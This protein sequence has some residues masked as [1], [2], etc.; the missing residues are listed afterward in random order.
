MSDDDGS[1]LR[2]LR[3]MWSELDPAPDGLV[4][5]M[6]FA[7]E[8]E[9]LDVDLSPT[10]LDRCGGVE[11]AGAR[12]GDQESARTVTFGSD[13]LTVIITL[14]GSAEEGHRLDGW[15]VPAE[16]LRVE[17]RTAH[18]SRWTVADATGRFVVDGLPSGLVQLV[19]QP[20]EGVP[21]ALTR[22]VVTPSLQL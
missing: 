10:L 6:L 19:L 7:L 1:L 22:P 5:R 18:G 14:S 2:R 21:S 16:P 8:L 20:V 15:L 4:D 3:Q 11:L 9:Q 13:S 17:L 12:S